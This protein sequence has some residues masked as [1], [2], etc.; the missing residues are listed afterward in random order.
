M[1]AFDLGQVSLDLAEEAGLPDIYYQPINGQVWIPIET[2]LIKDGFITA[3]KTAIEEIRAK[4]VIDSTTVEDA[5]AKY[6]ASSLRGAKRQFS[7]PENRIRT[8]ID[9]DLTNPWLQDFLEYFL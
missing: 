2:T 4:G 8:R 6:G 5:W 1:M 3:W 7:I 9:A